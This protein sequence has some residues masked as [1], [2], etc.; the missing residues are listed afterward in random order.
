MRLSRKL[1][2][3]AAA[4]VVPFLVGQSWA[5]AATAQDD[6]SIMGLSF[7]STGGSTVLC[8]IEASH[9]VDSDSGLLEVALFTDGNPPCRGALFLDVQYVNRHDEAARI[10]A[11]SRGSTSQFATIE[12]AG[13]TAVTVDYSVSFDDCSANCIH[14][15][16]TK[17]K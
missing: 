17:T 8:N 3:G 2:L 11:D 7:T 10:H 9:T 6:D 12:D 14:N 15:L 1:A 16:Q 4:G 13:S 5:A